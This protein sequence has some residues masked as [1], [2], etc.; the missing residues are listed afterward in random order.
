[1]WVSSALPAGA[2]DLAVHREICGAAALYFERFS[3]QEL[4]ERVVEVAHSPR[5][6]AQLSKAGI[7]RST[8]FSWKSHVDRIVALA[9][10]LIS[11]SG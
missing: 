9:K 10:S 4:A 5:L 11:K 7:E 1:M 8:A 2:S 3:P 6:A